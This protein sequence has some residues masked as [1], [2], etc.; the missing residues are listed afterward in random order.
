MTITLELHVIKF[1]STAFDCRTAVAILSM[2]LGINFS[3]YIPEF[4]DITN[5]GGGV[6]NYATDIGSTDDL[7][8][9]KP[10][11]I[12]HVDSNLNLEAM[13]SSTNSLNTG[14]QNGIFFLL[15]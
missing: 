5:G 7:N 9:K 14:V 1:F 8:N 10:L 13:G 15:N 4:K 12:M 11:K 6:V 2:P 3:Q